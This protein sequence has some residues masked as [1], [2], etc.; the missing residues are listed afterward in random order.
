MVGFGS[1][2]Y[3]AKNDIS[4]LE[5]ADNLPETNNKNV[6][7]FSTAGITSESKKIKDHS[8]IREKL[9]TKGYIAL[10]NFS[11]KDLILIVF[12]DYLVELIRADLMQMTLKN[13]E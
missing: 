9:E 8:T 3:S 12:P 7:L 4:L 6:F 1:G 11:A 5:I 2:I 13:A 10:M